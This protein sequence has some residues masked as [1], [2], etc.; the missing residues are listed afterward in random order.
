MHGQP[1]PF[2][3]GIEGRRPMPR[4]AEDFTDPASCG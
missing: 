3:D 4:A 2:W 1:G